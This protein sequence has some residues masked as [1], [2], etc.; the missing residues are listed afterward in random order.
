MCRLIFGLTARETFLIWTITR[1]TRL[2]ASLTDEEKRKNAP[3]S[4]LPDIRSSNAVTIRASRHSSERS[5]APIASGS[6]YLMQTDRTCFKSVSPIKIFSMP[7]IFRL[8]MPE[9]T[10]C[11]KI[12]ATRARS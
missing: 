9:S 11:V 5:A 6:G 2:K 8:R 12:S 7:S 4:A 10:A 1:P 3:F